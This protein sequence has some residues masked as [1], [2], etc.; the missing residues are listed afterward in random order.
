M[1]NINCTTINEGMSS[2]FSSKNGEI[3]PLS[4]GNY[5]VVLN[6]ESTQTD[7]S[8]P[9]CGNKAD[10]IHQKHLKIIHGGSFNETPVDLSL[11]RRRFLCETCDRTFMERFESLPLYARQILDVEYAIIHAM[12]KRTLSDVSDSYGISP[13]TIARIIKKHW[14]KEQK[15]QLRGSYKYL[16][17]DEIF[18]KR[19]SNNEAIYYWILNDISEYGKVTTIMIEIG[20]TKD[21]VVE[22]LKKL[23][24]VDKVLAVCIDMWRQYADA[25]ELVFPNA[26][27][28]IDGFHVLQLA[29]REFDKLRK[30]LGNTLLEKKALKTDAKLL[31]TNLFNLKDEEL[32]KVESYLKIYPEL[33]KAYFLNQELY[34]FYRMKDYEQA[35]EY[36]AKW[37]G[38]VLDSGI[39]EL[40]NVLNTI[41]NWLPYIMNKFIHKISN[42][43]TEGKN[44][45]IR[46]IIRQGFHYGITTL[47][48]R[49]LAHDERKCRKIWQLKQ[50]KLE[51]KQKN[52]KL[53][54]V[55]KAS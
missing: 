16:S 23:L 17:M 47:R 44:N 4:Y 5:G 9:R 46:T 15:I 14:D 54:L 49:V 39:T 55:K 45:L 6:I 50:L 32:D 21:E 40:Q 10:H 25:I 34:E 48:A 37:S 29:E 52:L 1:L 18:Y 38:E 28:V 3:I 26:L 42:G 11:E 13:Q 53:K 51:R 20:R 31:T 36:I 27:I 22:R 12:A 33:E 7:I 24:N 8:C 2:C 41:E 43:K 19:D 35:L 30:R